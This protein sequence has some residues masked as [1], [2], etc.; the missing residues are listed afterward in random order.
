MH[1]TS[2][3]DLDSVT[4]GFSSD[5]NTPLISPMQGSTG[6]LQVALDLVQSA[7]DTATS[8][9]SRGDQGSSSSQ[10]SSTASL[11]SFSRA[12]SGIDGIAEHGEYVGEGE[13]ID[14]EEGDEEEGDEDE[15]DDGDDD[16]IEEEDE[17]DVE[18]MTF[19]TNTRL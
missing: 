1:S 17:E 13:D 7:T 16:V 18:D 8:K 15:F 11:M 12:H 5:V 10:S 2:Q 19:V 3:D 6:M 9:H 14:D 4:G